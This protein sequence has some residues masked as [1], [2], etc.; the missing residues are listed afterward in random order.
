M[1]V[2]VADGWQQ[3]RRARGG[4]DTPHGPVVGMGGGTST[5]VIELGGVA[6]TSIVTLVHRRGKG[7]QE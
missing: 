3:A 5:T 4:G 2:V 1:S 6:V 7:S